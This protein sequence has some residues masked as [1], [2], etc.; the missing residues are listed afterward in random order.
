MKKYLLALAIL[1]AFAEH[2]GVAQN[3]KATM[4]TE[5]NTN[6]P[7]N[8][9]GLITPAI[10]RT[11]LNDIVTA[12]QQATKTR[13]IG[14]SSDTIVVGDYGNLLTYNNAGAVAVAIA[15]AT[16]NFATF[17]T[18]VKNIGAGLVTITPTVSTINGAGTFSLAQ[19]QTAWIISDGT[20]YRVYGFQ[21]DISQTAWTAFTLSP[22]CGTATF[23]VNSARFKQ[24]GKTVFWEFDVTTTAIGSCVTTYT[25]NLPVTSNSSAVSAAREQATGGGVLG[26]A[27]IVG[28]SATADVRKSANAVFL[29]NE[30]WLSSGVYESQ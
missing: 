12:Y 4:T 13:D 15:Q 21:S 20:N 25:V 10:T 1:L 5:V 29:V 6:L 9:T 23:T 7:D 18:F 24:T 22:V 17:N 19:N 16:G 2:P 30:R 14:G 27:Q 3:T 26:A 11:T 8:T 28:S